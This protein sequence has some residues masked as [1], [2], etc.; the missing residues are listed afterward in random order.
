MEIESK[1][2]TIKDVN[3]VYAYK[4]TGALVRKLG[5]KKI[6]SEERGFAFDLNFDDLMMIGYKLS[7][8][9]T[10]DYTG[11]PFFGSENDT[12]A[13][14]LERIDDRKG[15][16]RGNIAIVGARAN[17]LKDK[18]IDKVHQDS[19]LQMTKEDIKIVNAMIPRLQVKGYLEALKSKYLPCYEDRDSLTDLI[20]SK[21]FLEA[22][23]LRDEKTEKIIKGASEGEI[24]TLHGVESSVDTQKLPSEGEQD[25]AEVTTKAADPVVD[26][27]E[28]SQLPEDVAVAMGYAALCKSMGKFMPVTIT[29]SQYKAVYTNKRCPF[30]G[31]ELT[32]RFPVIID[33][34]KPLEAG[35]IKMTSAKVGFALNQLLDATGQSLNDLAKNMKKMVN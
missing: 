7:G 14:T 20:D 22:I 18:F 33:R 35:N 10:C 32:E 27:P 25:Q 15:Y 23:L 8:N 4:D 31:E 2:A 11:L 3:R 29:F 13:P 24:I 9:G 1:I 34:T 21:N 19:D 28:E 30:T 5:N 16:V 12:Y 26:T 6:N 17:Y